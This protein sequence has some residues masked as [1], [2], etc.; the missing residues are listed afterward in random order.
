MVLVELAAEEGLERVA[1]AAVSPEP[2]DRLS[3]RAAS[4]EWSLP[5]Y[6]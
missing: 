6:S 4:N 1:V 5:Y 2:L 3:Q